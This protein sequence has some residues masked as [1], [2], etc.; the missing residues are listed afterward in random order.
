MTSSL[1]S[2][3]ISSMVVWGFFE[4]RKTNKDKKLFQHQPLHTLT[5]S[6]YV[7]EIDQLLVIA[8]EKSD[9]SN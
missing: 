5:S 9:R 7:V 2:Y 3:F 1:L 6:C 4:S 8:N